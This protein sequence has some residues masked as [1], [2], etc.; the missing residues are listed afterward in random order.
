MSVS[1]IPKKKVDKKI[2]KS[3]DK[4]ETIWYIKNAA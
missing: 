1:N 4:T 3:V 2:K